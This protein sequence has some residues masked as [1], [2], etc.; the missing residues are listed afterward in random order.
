MNEILTEEDISQLLDCDLKKIISLFEDGSFPGIN[1]GKKWICPKDL[2]I[3]FLN[4]KAL[5]RF[6]RSK[7]ARLGIERK[8]A[9]G[10]LVQIGRRPENIA[11]HAAKR[12]AARKRRTA[13]WANLE[14]IKEIYAI[15]ARLSKDTGVPHHVDHIIPMQ[16]VFVS[17]LHVESN[18]QVITATENMS[19]HNRFEVGVFNE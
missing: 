2:F 1:L 9:S 12:R 8:I 3:D 14:K 6:V 19:K 5:T 4:K 7:A 16:G 10:E 18:L 11:H 13:S 15:A 17:G